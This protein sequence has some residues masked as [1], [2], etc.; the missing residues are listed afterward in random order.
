MGITSAGLLFLPTHIAGDAALQ[1]NI[2]R[3]EWSPQ[4]VVNLILTPSDR[5]L[6]LGD[7]TPLYFDPQRTTYA[8]TWDKNP[9]VTTL[10]V[11]TS[12]TPTATLP[13]PDKWSTELKRAGYSHILI[14]FAELNRLQ[15]SGFLDPSLNPE[16]IAAWAQS[17]EVV[18]AWPQTGQVLIKLR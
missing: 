16:Q 18:Q 13:P 5:V 10:G 17:M 7:T 2:D 15:V 11:A 6:L 14:N 12:K 4:Q 8:T 1:K 9:F 3:K